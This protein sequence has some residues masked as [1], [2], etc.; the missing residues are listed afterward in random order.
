MKR[1]F[2][3][4]FTIFFLI[5]KNSPAAIY[6]VIDQ[7]SPEKKFPI[8]VADLIEQK[9]QSADVQGV[10]IADI[11]RNNLKLAGYFDIINTS[12]YLDRGP[13]LLPEQVP[14]ERWSQIGANVFVKGSYQKKGRDFIIELRLYD[15]NLKQMLVGKEYRV[16]Q[17]KAYAAV[18]RFADEVMLTLTGERGIFNTKIT[19]ACGPRGKEQIVMMNVDGTEREAITNNNTLNLSPNWSPDG[20]SLVYTSYAKF[21]PE[22]FLTEVAKKKS[23]RLTFNNMLNITPEFS[24][25]GN[26][27]AYSTSMSGDPDIHLIDKTGKEIGQ[28]TKSFGIDISPTWSPDGNYLAFASERAGNLHLF[29]TDKNGAE[30]KRLTFVGYQNDTPAWSPR[31]DKL[32]FVRRAS[33]AFNVFTMNAD[34]SQERQLTQ[35]SNNNENPA[36]SPDGRYLVFSSSRKKGTDLYLMMWDGSNQIPIT[37][38]GQCK[39]PDWSSWFNEVKKD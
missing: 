22:L 29:V 3:F 24:P 36:W 10:A 19:A 25:D 7:F 6:I 8:A 35:D 38:D 20:T 30:P 31:N 18:H 15:P 12:T 5:P 34:G 21:F 37:T 26:S 23:T 39:T 11:L 17:D 32:A 27:I 1:Y 16:K 4:L 14:Y 2:L 9:S 13:T 28:L 33:G